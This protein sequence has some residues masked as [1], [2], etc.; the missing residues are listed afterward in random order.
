MY[1]LTSVHEIVCYNVVVGTYVQNTFFIECD[2]M[3]NFM[4]AQSCWYN[5]PVLTTFYTHAV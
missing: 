4:P 3:D 2:L 5:I 1:H